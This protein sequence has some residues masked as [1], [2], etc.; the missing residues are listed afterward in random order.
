MPNNSQ[1][2]RT[3]SKHKLHFDAIILINKAHQ[4]AIGLRFIRLLSVFVNSTSFLLIKIHIKP[5]ML[6]AKTKMKYH[7]QF[8]QI[9][10]LKLLLIFVHLN[11]S[12]TGKTIH[13]QLNTNNFGRCLLLLPWRVHYIHNNVSYWLLSRVLMVWYYIIFGPAACKKL[14]TWKH[15][16]AEHSSILPTQ[17]LTFSF[18]F[19]PYNNELYSNQKGPWT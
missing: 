16:C 8:N 3:R 4:Q 18:L 7:Q 17:L 12:P 15:V 19:Q 11:P 13:L 6:L 10:I 9:L 1:P 14:W 5:S 2:N